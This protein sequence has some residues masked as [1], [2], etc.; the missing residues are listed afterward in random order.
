M[1]NHM[2][3]ALNALDTIWKSYSFDRLISFMDA[4]LIRDV[5][6]EIDGINFTVS[7]TVDIQHLLVVD[8]GE[9]DC[10]LNFPL[11]QNGPVMGI[12]TSKQS[13][14]SKIGSC[15]DGWSMACKLCG[16]YTAEALNEIVN[17]LLTQVLQDHM[18]TLCNVNVIMIRANELNAK[19]SSKGTRKTKTETTEEGKAYVLYG[20][21]REKFVPKAIG[22]D[23]MKLHT[24]KTMRDNREMYIYEDGVYRTNC[25]SLIETLASTMLGDESTDARVK[26]TVNHIKRMTFVD[27]ESFNSDANI[28]ILNLKNGLL[29]VNTGELMPHTPDFLS[30]IRINIT[31][32]PDAKCPHINKFLNDVVAE[33][34]REKDVITLI[35][36]AAVIMVPLIVNKAFLL[37]GAKA[38]NGKSTF[39]EII[40]TIIGEENYSSVPLNELQSDKFSSSELHLMLAN[41]AAELPSA[42]I[43]ET[44]KFNGLVTG[45]ERIRAQKKFGHA[46]KFKNKAR[47]LFSANKPPVVS[48]EANQR[49]YFRRWQIVDF[50]HIFDKEHGNEDRDIISKLTDEQELSGFLN[51][52][53]PYLKRMLETKGFTYESS[54]DDVRE[55]YTAISNPVQAF[56]EN[57]IEFVDDAFVTPYVLKKDMLRA[58]QLF[59]NHHGA[60]VDK[61]T[62]EQLTKRLNGDKHYDFKSKEY[63]FYRQPLTKMGAYKNIIFRDKLLNM[64]PEERFYVYTEDC[65]IM[66]DPANLTASMTDRTDALRRVPKVIHEGIKIKNNT[67]LKVTKIETEI[68]TP[69]NDPTYD[70][71]KALDECLSELS[72]SKEVMT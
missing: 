59:C 1:T 16:K 53:L 42:M 31:Y 64:F 35:E 32:D 24:I 65:D 60:S 19:K 47:L 72:A 52:M 7:E 14:E 56:I 20:T 23:I 28:H 33:S 71:M 67:P 12:D 34:R 18:Q 39:I 3:T 27:R 46:F 8:Y 30:T 61:W 21:P 50:P 62:Q 25:E 2:A 5:R 55:A 57:C 4:S 68:E 63:T 38:Q 43:D 13:I 69:A 11:I 29:N 54:A 49:S 9:I 40:Q 70:N 22:D 26:E 66:E 36:M 44:D 51:V 48:T 10:R 6:Y 17:K 41:I 37:T 15:Y 45:K 58:F